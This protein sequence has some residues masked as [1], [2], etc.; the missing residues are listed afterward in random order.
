MDSAV[1]GRFLNVAGSAVDLGGGGVTVSSLI[2]FEE[3]SGNWAAP[4]WN[5]A[6]PG[7]GSWFS[8]STAMTLTT[9]S[10]GLTITGNTGAIYLTS[11]SGDRKFAVRYSSGLGVLFPRWVS[12]ASY[13]SWTPNLDGTNG[14]FRIRNG[15]ANTDETA[16]SLFAS[17]NEYGVEVIG[18]TINFY[19]AGALIASRS[20]ATHSTATAIAFGNSNTTGSIKIERFKAGVTSLP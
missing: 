13:V 20:T 16:A 2:G 8:T 3:T 11:G 1:T 7:I 10:A 12:S 14:R 5:L 18:N 19:A 9:D 4:V 17:A 6:S 15:G